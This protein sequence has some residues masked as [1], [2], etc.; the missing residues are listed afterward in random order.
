MAL[1]DKHQ[2]KFNIHKDAK[3]LMEAIEKRFG[4]VK[5]SS[6]SSQTTQ[7]IAFVSSNN[8]NNTN[9]SVNVVPSVS[10]AS[11]KATFS[12][13][14]NV[15][16]LSDAVIYSFFASQS[17]SPQLDN[18]DLKQ[19]DHD[20][21]EEMDLKW[22]MA[23]L[24]MRAKRECRSPR[25]NRN[26]EAPRRTIPVETFSKNL[27]KL[28][29]S[30]V[31]DKTG[32]GFDSQVFNCQ[33]FDCEELHSHE[34]DNSVPKSTENDRYKSGE[35]YHA[36]PPPYTGTFMP[37]KPDL[38][39][40]DAPNASE[41]VANVVTIVS[42]T[43]KPGKDM[44]KTHSPDAPIIKDW[45]TDS[46]DETKNES[47]PKQKE[48]SFVLT[49][50][51][52]K[53]PRESVKKDEHP[54][55]AENLRTTNQKSRGHTNSW[56]RKACFVCK[57]LNHLIKDCDYY[58]KQMV[59]K[60]AWNNAMR[61]NHHNSARMTHPHSNRNVVPIAV[62]TRLRLVSLNAARPVSTAVPQ[63]TM[64]SPSPV[65]H[66]VNKAHSPIRRPINHIPVTKNSN[67]H[68]RVPR[69]MMKKP[70][71]TG[72]GNQNIQVSHGLGPQK[73]LS[74]LFDVEGNPQQALKDKG[75]IDSGCSRHMTE[76]ISFLS[77]FKE[78]NRGY[79][80]FGG[81]PKS[82]KITR[83]DIECVVLSSDYKVPDENH[84][85][86]RVLRENNMHNVDLKNVVPLGDL[87]CLFSNATL[88]ESNLWRRRLGHINFKTMNKLVKFYGMKGIKREFSVARTPQHN[89]V[90]ERKNRTLIEASRTRL[91]D[92][93]LHM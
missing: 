84:I 77:D 79:V 17:N 41:S 30:Q 11:S 74:F 4:E 31:S 48:Q 16:S 33:V 72:C 43:N 88:D 55:Q 54:K 71:Q 45:T 82:G 50:E 60:H 25:D 78:I 62:L 9:E 23:M 63:S 69:I 12:T 73:T 67:F 83:K 89:R 85:L 3:T 38:V 18:E 61:V 90:A 35:G 80:A 57:S 70:Q 37:S 75:V 39:F 29:E 14:P 49:F 93:L 10:A 6:T 7:N 26:K 36:V 53:T 34:S 5:S 24:T 32:L 76:N 40:N 8:T 15:D 65:K 1:P 64:K 46:E 51:H 66:V 42:S 58:E 86:L 52:V 92:S 47:V 59:Q 19:I 2:L 13:L 91:A 27:S 28:L 87:T 68:K 44:S 81:N 20:D 56:N 22:H 21:L